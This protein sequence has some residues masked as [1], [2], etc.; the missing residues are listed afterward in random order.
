MRRPAVPLPLLLVGVLLLAGIAGAVMLT[1]AGRDAEPPRAGAFV[2]PSSAVRAISRDVQQAR[3]GSIVLGSVEG[4]VTGALGSATAVYA[5]RPARAEDV[6]SG[7]WV[8]V[9]GVPNEVL[10]FAI[11]RVV[12]IPAALAPSADGDGVPRLGGLAG[13]ETSRDPRE[14]PVIAGRV[15]AVSGSSIT[16]TSRERTMTIDIAAPG[17]LRRI[18]RAAAADVHEGDRLA[19]VPPRSGA[20][21]D[22]A[23]AVL[24]E[25]LD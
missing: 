8:T 18:E 1:M 21:L 19:Y 22:E 7:D 4:S 14:R 11:R 16:I 15:T 17:P 5:V 2:A 24:I 3:S 12:V 10:N 23:P 20:P 13:Y 25:R 6:R 9:V